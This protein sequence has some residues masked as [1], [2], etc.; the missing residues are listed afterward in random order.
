MRII[1]IGSTRI[2][3]LPLQYRGHKEVVLGDAAG[4]HIVEINVAPD[5]AVDIH[6]IAERK[7][8]HG[9]IAF[10]HVRI[11]SM[12][13]DEVIEDGTVVIADGRINLAGIRTR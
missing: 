2:R 6:L 7:Y 1:C 10:R 8:G 3:S 5:E 12:K 11:L 4:N 9:S 13:G